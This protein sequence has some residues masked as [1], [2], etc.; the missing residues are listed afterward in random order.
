MMP[1]NTALSASTE[2]GSFSS[3]ERFWDMKNYYS[4]L[5]LISSNSPTGSDLKQ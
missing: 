5:F 4:E 1:P 2:K 3:E